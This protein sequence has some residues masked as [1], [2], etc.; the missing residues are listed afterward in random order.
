MESNRSPLELQAADALRRARRLPVG[1]ERND[2][3]QLATGLL[4]LHRR[5]MEALVE[6]RRVMIRELPHAEALE[7]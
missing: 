6:N 2:L 1:A 7:A 3:R 5:G 4:W